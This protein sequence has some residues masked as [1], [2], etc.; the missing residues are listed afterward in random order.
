MLSNFAVID[1]TM[2]VTPKDTFAL[3]HEGPIGVFNDLL[4]ET[5]YN[6]LM[7]EQTQRFSQNHNGWVGI[8][9]KYW[10]TAIIPDQ[11]VPFEAKF[12]YRE[13]LE[14][15]NFKVSY[16][17]HKF[18]LPEGQTLSTTHNLFAGPK[19]VNILD[20]HQTTYN[21]PKFDHAVDFGWVLYSD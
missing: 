4:T 6:D 9:D 14:R 5:G 1:R 8:T 16:I 3:L 18:S 15:H 13:V 20:E 2:D 12:E 11:N 7:N 19:E 10:L 17:G 21:A